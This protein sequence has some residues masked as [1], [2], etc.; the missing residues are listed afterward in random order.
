M[1]HMVLI[2][3]KGYTMRQFDLPWFQQLGLD[4]CLCT[5]IYTK[6]K[7]TKLSLSKENMYKRLDFDSKAI[8]LVSLGF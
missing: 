4:K 3:G 2:Y 7:A 1:V 8:S 6:K 5:T